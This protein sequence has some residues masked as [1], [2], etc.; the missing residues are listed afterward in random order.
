MLK[1]RLALLFRR[2]TPRADGERL[3]RVFFTHPLEC[4]LHKLKGTGLQLRVVLHL[5]RA[6]RENAA[7]A[8]LVIEI[9][10]QHALIVAELA[11]N[12]ADIAFN[13]CPA[14]RIAHLVAPRARRR[15]AVVLARHGRLLRA[16]VRLVAGETAVVHQ[17][18]HGAEPATV[19]NRQKAVDARHQ[20][21]AVV[22]PDD[23]RQVDAQG[24]IARL[25][26]PAQLALDGG[27][28]EGLFLPDIGPV[29][30][31]RRQIVKPAQ[32]AFLL[33]PRLCLLPAPLLFHYAS[34]Y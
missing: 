19:G 3:G 26:R 22:L 25:R 33:I 1:E 9:P 6:G 30:R 13:V 27:G 34:S 12:V 5:L 10:Q 2:Q 24:V 7:V 20:A 29:H 21:V 8:R 15:L 31:R 23:K 14:V 28:I 32:P 17:G 18:Q 4:E 11:D 16:K